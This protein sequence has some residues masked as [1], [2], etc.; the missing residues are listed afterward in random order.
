MP[1]YHAS[2]VKYSLQR[3][4][5][6]VFVFL[7][8]GKFLIR[9]SSTL[10]IFYL[11]IRWLF[12]IDTP[13]TGDAMF[14]SPVKDTRHCTIYSL[15]WLFKDLL[16]SFFILQFY[17]ALRS[18]GLRWPIAVGLRPSFSASVNIF[19][20][21]TICPIYTNVLCLIDWLIGLDFTP[22]RQISVI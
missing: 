3:Y 5:L 10:L 21:R 12:I 9:W 22:Y 20:S 16:F 17:P 14:I 8:Y 18:P 13:L 2:C 15:Q 6:I 1:C 4:V 11:C 7:W 19:F